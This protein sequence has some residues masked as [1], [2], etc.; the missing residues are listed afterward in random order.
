MNR[1]QQLLFAAGNE[2]YDFSSTADTE[3]KAAAQQVAAAQ[4]NIKKAK[5]RAVL[6]EAL[7]IRQHR[8]RRRALDVQDNEA[9]SL[10]SSQQ[11]SECRRQLALRELERTQRQDATSRRDALT[12]HQA[13]L[14]WERKRQH[15]VSAAAAKAKA[16]IERRRMKNTT[17]DQ[18]SNE[19]CI[20]GEGALKTM[21]RRVS[22]DGPEQS[23]SIRN[24]EPFCFLEAVQTSL[25]LTPNQIRELLMNRGKVCLGKSAHL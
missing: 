10:S 17:E 16:A 5:E 22:A 14:E 15:R 2:P 6:H 21:L 12:Q 1:R 23:S 19:V 24:I 9:K 8:Q 7:K 13:L 25:Q 20:T 3:D 4:W 11:N 18:G